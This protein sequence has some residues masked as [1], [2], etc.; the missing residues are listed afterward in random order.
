MNILHVCKK[1]PLALGGDA[2]VVANLQKQQ[3][4]AAHQVAIVTSNCDE[5]QCGAHIYKL[6]LKDTPAGLDVITLRRMASLLV[7]LFK[8]FVILPKERPDVIHTHS[9]DMAFFASFA[10]RLYGIPIVHT[11]HIVTF[12]DATQPALRRRC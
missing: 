7:L 3:Q 9:I 1:Y 5:I 8:M 12:Y 10:A 11:F 2:V 4:A 6:G